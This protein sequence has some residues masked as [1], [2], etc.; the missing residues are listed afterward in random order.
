MNMDNQKNF[1][2]A[3]FQGKIVK[4][5]EAKVNIMTNAL[6]YGTGI[7]GGI[8][9]YVSSDNE[10]VNIFRIED[11][12]SRFLKSLKIINKQIK[13]PLGDLVSITLDVCR[14]NNPKTDCYIRPFAY[15]SDFGISPDLSPAVFDFALYMIP[16]GEYLS[17]SKGLKLAF[18]NWIRI[19]DNMIPA[20]AKLCGGY[21]NSSLA[22]ADAVKLGYDDALMLSTD[23]HVAEGSAAN[24]FIV[25][26]GVLITAPKYSDVLEG[27]TRR[28]IIQIAKESGI[29]VEEREIDRTEVYIA[30]EA[31]LSGTG[32]QVAW[33]REVDGR[34]IGN[35]NIG[36]ISSKLQSLFFDIVRAKEKKYSGWLTKI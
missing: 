7:F 29:S 31:F 26:D 8:R 15:A 3:F 35:G 20:R 36:Q 14:K 27:I 30:D 19:S 12:Y 32:V 18:S 23:G 28:T 21:I 16:L 34:I 33:V 2:F 5:S 1:P 13:F 11:H 25:R 24:F 10:S 22:K 4:T 17:V 6:Q 9:G